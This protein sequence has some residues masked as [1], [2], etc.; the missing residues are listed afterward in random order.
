[1]YAIRSYYD[2]RP[3][4][5]EIQPASLGLRHPRTRITSYNVCYTKL[6]RFDFYPG[7]NGYRLPTEAEW[8]Y[9]AR[10]AG[11]EGFEYAGSD[12]PEEVAWFGNP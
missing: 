6:L 11:S 10:G 1:M 2:R 12:A 8:E 5:L 9:A 3:A 7:A 4:D